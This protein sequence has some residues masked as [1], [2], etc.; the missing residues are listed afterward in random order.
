MFE[1]LF[2]WITGAGFALV[3]ILILAVAYFGA[4]EEGRKK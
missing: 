4:M 2:R 1:E 3:W